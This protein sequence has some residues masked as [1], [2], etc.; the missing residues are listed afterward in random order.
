MSSFVLAKKLDWWIEHNQNVLF[1]GR[2]G[3]GKSTIVLDAFKRN[4]LNFLYFS[5]ATI[6]PW[7]DFVGVPCEKQENKIPE[8]FYIIKELY[9]IDRNLAIEW[10]SNNWKMSEKNSLSIVEHAL[11]AD[12]GRS[13]LEL[14]RPH[15]IDPNTVEAMFFD[16]ANRSKPKV[17]NALMELT[18]F[19]TIN[20]T[21]FPKL[22]IIWAA[23]N[24]DDDNE[25]TYNV[26]KMD[27]AQTDRYHIHI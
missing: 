17:Q 12:P 23:I 15:R 1:V 5:A 19:K 2:Q 3:V 4:K 7:V 18:Q 9:K 13:H 22:K 14:I 26:E 21:P 20:G 27:V 8:E 11:Q 24:P 25:I 10:V 6:D 16:E